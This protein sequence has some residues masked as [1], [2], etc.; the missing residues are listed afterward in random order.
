MKKLY[1]LLILL[2]IVFITSSCIEDDDFTVPVTSEVVLDAPVGTVD[3]QKIINQYENTFAGRQPIPITFLENAGYIEGYVISSDEAG[4]FFK[5]LVIQNQAENPTVGVNVKIDVAPLFTRLEFGRRVYIKLDGLTLSEANGVYAL[6]FG[7][8]LNGIQAARFDD[9][10][11]RDE[12]TVTIVPKE[13]SLSDVS[14]LHENQWVRLSNVQFADDE[15]GNSFAS[16]LGDTFDGDRKLKT[17]E[18]FFID[19]IIYQTSTFADFKAVKIPNGSGSV[20]A[21]VSRDF[22]DEFFVLNSNSPEDFDFDPAI[23]CE[24]QV[25]QCGIADGPGEIVLLEETFDSEIK[26]RPTTPAGWTNFIESGTT[27]WKNYLNEETNNP[28]TRVTNFGSKDESSIAW[29]ITP[30][31]NFDSQT[32]EVLNF[33]SSNSFPDG[34]VLAVLFSDNWDGTSAGVGAA[35]WN[36]LADTTVIP[37]TA[38]SNVFISS[39]NISLECLAGTGAIAFKYIASESDASGRDGAFNGTYELDDVKITSD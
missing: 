39:G 16:E 37:N 2:F 1:P 31:L 30:Q 13:L 23:R 9:Y 6:G 25:I 11:I 12:E 7:T 28:G 24:F 3:I 26:N 18:E 34:S 17:C 35:T 21:I 38:S 27:S 33:I 14:S 36:P 4:N 10:I 5:E 20:N 22:K 15:L 29:L 32:G 8:E 19:P